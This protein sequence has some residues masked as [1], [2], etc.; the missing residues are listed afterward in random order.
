AVAD[1]ERR[2]GQAS[3]RLA[4]LQR[5]QEEGTGL[6]AGVRRV[7][8]AQREGALR[9]IRGTVAELIAVDAQYDT[10]IEV[11]LGGHLQDVVVERWADAEAAI[12]L[13]KQAKA[14]RATFQP[15]DT[16]ARRGERP[17]PRELDRLGGVHGIASDLV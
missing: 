5:V 11:A 6:H 7:M 17:A 4:V 2:L 10:A 3:N 14:G 1:A 16:L 13:L 15:L 12:A 8:Q 9:G